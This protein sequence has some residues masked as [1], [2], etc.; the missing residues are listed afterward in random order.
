MQEKMKKKARKHEGLTETRATKGTL[1][2][3]EQAPCEADRTSYAVSGG[4]IRALAAARDP[5]L[6]SP[7]SLRKPLESG[8]SAE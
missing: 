2:S 4:A 1:T 3:G 6:N 8:R 5:T 7:S